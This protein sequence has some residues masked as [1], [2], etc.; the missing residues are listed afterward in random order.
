MRARL[1]LVTSLLAFALLAGALPSSVV[2]EALEPTSVTTIPAAIDQG[3]AGPLVGVLPTSEAYQ[4]AAEVVAGLKAGVP[5]PPPVA[6][7]AQLSVISALSEGAVRAA[8]QTGTSTATTSADRAAL[9][10][11]STGFLRGTLESV[12]SLD[13]AS[14]LAAFRAGAEGAFRGVVE[15]VT[16]AE[17]RLSA[18]Q[19]E[20]YAQG[21]ADAMLHDVSAHASTLSVVAGSPAL[22]DVATYVSDIT[23]QH[24]QALPTTATAQ[25]LDALGSFGGGEAQGVLVGVLSAFPTG[26][27]T[28][29]KADVRAWVDGIARGHQGT[30][31]WSGQGSPTLLAAW[32]EDV[33]RAGIAAVKD[34]RRDLAGSSTQAALDDLGAWGAGLASGGIEHLGR[35]PDQ[36]G[37]LQDDA[38]AYAEGLVEPAVDLI[39][40]LPATASVDP[41]AVQAYANGLTGG[42]DDLGAATADTSVLFARYA[43]GL[44]AA[45]RAFPSDAKPQQVFILEAFA[46]G[47]TN[48]IGARLASVQ[49]A[50]APGTDALF[51]D[52]LAEGFADAASQIAGNRGPGGSPTLTSELTDGLA[53]GFLETKDPATLWRDFDGYADA[54]ETWF[55]TLVPG[56]AFGPLL[57]AS[58][59]GVDGAAAAARAWGVE[60]GAAPV[61]WAANAGKGLTPEAFGAKNDLLFL[62]SFA[63]ETTNRTLAATIDPGS[64]VRLDDVPRMRAAMES[65]VGNVA[66]NATAIP[67]EQAARTIAEGNVAS[68]A[69]R[70]ADAATAPLGWLDPRIGATQDAANATLVRLTDNATAISRFVNSTYA[71]GVVTMLEAVGDGVQE[72]AALAKQHG[73][74]RAGNLTLAWSQ[75]VVDAVLAAPIPAVQAD[76]T[77]RATWLAALTAAA[78]ETSSRA[79]S[80]QA[81]ATYDYA[82][83]VVAWVLARP[84]DPLPDLSKMHVPLA[85]WADATTQDA[86]A[87][88]PPAMSEDERE[89]YVA[90]ST[91]VARAVTSLPTPDALS[92]T[93]GQLAALLGYVGGVQAG[94]SLVQGDV[95][96][97]Q[98][99]TL[100]QL[101]LS[102]QCGD[103][104]TGGGGD[105]CTAN[106]P[107]PC[108]PDCEGDKECSSVKTCPDEVAAR[109]AAN[110]GSWSE[111]VT[112][113]A[114]RQMPDT[115]PTQNGIAA[116]ARWATD[117]LAGNGVRV[118]LTEPSVTPDGPRGPA[119]AFA[120]A[121]PGDVQAFA[122]ALAQGYAPLVQLP[123]DATLERL[124]GLADPASRWA[125]ALQQAAADHYVGD[126]PGYSPTAPGTPAPPG[127]LDDAAVQAWLDAMWAAVPALYR[128][129]GSTP[130]PSTAFLR[131]YGWHLDYVVFQAVAQGGIDA[132]T[133]TRERA[134]QTGDAITPKTGALDAFALGLLQSANATV[135]DPARTDA[136]VLA[137]HLKGAA[138]G[139]VGA[140]LDAKAGVTGAQ[141]VAV[142]AFAMALAD[143]AWVPAPPT[144]VPV[145]TLSQGDDEDEQDEDAPPSQSA[146]A[147]DDGEPNP[148]EAFLANVEAHAKGVAS[149]ALA[150]PTDPLAA[151]A[152]AY[153]DALLLYAETVKAAALGVPPVSPD[154]G[155]AARLQA[156][157]QGEATAALGHPPALTADRVGPNPDAA[158]AVAYLRALAG[159]ASW[160]LLADVQANATQA[161]AAAAAGLALLCPTPTQPTECARIGEG[162]GSGV[163]D[164]VPSGLPPAPTLDA[165]LAGAAKGIADA[166]PPADPSVDDDIV[167][168]ILRGLPPGAPD[169][170]PVADAVAQAVAQNAPRLPPDVPGPLAEALAAA[171]SGKPPAQVEA[172]AAGAAMLVA[173][174]PQSTAANA[175]AQVSTFLNGATKPAIS[176]TDGQRE[177]PAADLDGTPVLSAVRGIRVVVIAPKADAPG[178][179][180]EVAYSPTDPKG[181]DAKRLTLAAADGRLTA[182]LRAAD[183]GATTLKFVLLQTTGGQTV[184]HDR[185]GQ[186]FALKA[187]RAAPAATTRAPAT[188]EHASFLVDWS[189]TDDV[190]VSTY[191]VE[192]QN[193]S[194]A[195]RPW[196][197]A[198]RGSSATFTGWPGASYRFRAAATDLAGNEGAPSAEAP[199]SVA[200]AAVADGP[201]DAP[202]V[203]FTAPAEGQ[204]FDDD[205]TAS[206]ASTDPDGTP[207]QVRVCVWRED[208]VLDVACPYEGPAGAFTV[209]A[210]AL[211]DGRWRLHATATDGAMTSEADSPVFELA[212]APPPLLGASAAFDGTRGTLVLGAGPEVDSAE[213][214]VGSLTVPLRDDGAEGDQRAG[215]GV[216]S[217][218]VRLEPGDYVATFLARSATGRE[219][220][221]QAAFH[222]DPDPAPSSADDGGSTPTTTTPP[223]TKERTPGAGLLLVALAALAGALLRR[224][225]G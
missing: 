79:T 148:R 142:Q 153:R 195:W 42:L 91:G 196:L 220:T 69:K 39:L 113:A 137:R 15:Q 34:A 169:A 102:T 20:A 28:P 157:A 156:W 95:A 185:D 127:S 206:V 166:T 75:G 136:D 49:K 74:A 81:N 181:A 112:R 225:E 165:A 58:L 211:P 21:L 154:E 19:H 92:W 12:P 5:T 80:A 212:R 202:V 3:A 45:V 170:G 132:A 46:E 82:D 78:V 100:C 129:L 96:S 214:R 13:D 150:V 139:G 130:L 40:H 41:D 65:Y 138:E 72:G 76:L 160:K 99:A 104:G 186:P 32:T 38:A 101:K 27:P 121:R 133:A 217:A 198:T 85:T 93:P 221:T 163:A 86:L 35:Q 120:T 161:Q 94:V 128:D 77:N 224:R 149:A 62:A 117:V 151:N 209:D 36:R 155:Y 24:A 172:L 25:Q 33:T 97:L 203:A 59:D 173:T 31:P 50:A 182:T 16:T 191:R 199:V 108:E 146:P 63:Q 115:S 183:L 144:P 14:S 66:A 205:F 190:G 18:S 201:N 6:T 1:V 178:T 219:A 106:C 61:E 105:P 194:G 68:A 48:R 119:W 107:P 208:D 131:D 84:A 118:N 8:V 109:Y 51:L 56:A 180:W 123:P 188:S 126:A 167:A 43:D 30:P 197:Q 152:L 187:D 7:T 55:G 179:T 171:L 60:M 26:I 83:E 175:Q 4:R 134:G 177:A 204:S 37:D 145:P 54:A 52:A 162:L 207:P 11:F 53:S 159:D 174:N 111:N 10:G 210:D 213:A 47:A 67:V 116:V 216:W 57:N 143:P 192:V 125:Q 223:A 17:P 135:V 70:F 2:E 193:G 64:G 44:V 164:V 23:R 73:D 124:V 114:L 147:A 168:G 122:E 110:V 140:I 88:L 98:N 222:V 176:V 22:A 218:K 158:L 87:R 215:D 89:A 71:R 9:R 189:A 29:H 200:G 141:L 90:Y 184:T 103:D